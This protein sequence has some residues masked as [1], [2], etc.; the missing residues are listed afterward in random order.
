MPNAKV[1]GYLLQ[2]ILYG[3]TDTRTGLIALRGPLKLSVRYQ[4]TWL[5]KK[6]I[7]FRSESA[8]DKC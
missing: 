2:N 7:I 5:M 6:L 1:K 4:N 3:H 8:K